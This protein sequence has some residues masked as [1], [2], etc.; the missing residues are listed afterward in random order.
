[1]KRLKSVTAGVLHYDFLV[2][3]TVPP[4]NQ[5]RRGARIN[6]SS[7]AQTFMNLKNSWRQC[8]LLIA[9]NFTQGDKVLTLTYD[10][11]HLPQDKAK[12]DWILYNKLI[13]ELRA[14][15]RKRGQELYA[16][17][18]TEGLHGLCSYDGF[19]DDTDWE[20]HRIHHHLV[21]NGTGPGDLEEI[22]SLWSY[23]CYVRLEP[24]DIHYYQELAKYLTKE[25]REFGRAKVG[26]RTWRCTRNLSKPTVEYDDVGDNL[27]LAP[28][29]GAVDIEHLD[30]P[31]PEGYG[32]LICMRY[33]LL[34][35]V[36]KALYSYTIGRHR[37][38]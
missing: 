28:P 23:G 30:K 25:A 2:P 29:P 22:K 19:M 3:I 11:A 13:R 10:N 35:V 16:L 34:P 4:G 12:A 8:E 5:K 27:T 31:N 38:R 36:E 6:P 9:A 1:M 33:L 14:I 21:I 7:A 26:E 15:R 20:D 17:Y 32:E 18:V 24:L 37:R